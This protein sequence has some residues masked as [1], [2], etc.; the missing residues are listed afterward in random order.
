[1]KESEQWRV[2]VAIE[3]PSKA[4]RRLVEHIGQLQDS[5]PE[6]RA[7]WGHQENLHLTLKFLGNIPATNVEAL[8]Q[9]VE[10][11]A[12]SARPFELLV[13][14]CGV[15]P[16]HGAPRVLWIGIDD[17]SGWLD[18]VYRALEDE[19]AGAGFEREKRPFHPHLT[20]ARVRKPEGSGRLA[21]VH[22]EIGF[23][24]LPVGVS[25][26]SVFRSELRNEGSKHT[27]LSRH[28]FSQQRQ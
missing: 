1:M 15:F 19:C 17:P 27:V 24:A 3:L 2:F 26:L 20:I 11:T 28:E 10:R 8:S 23:P 13:E 14:G 5:I 16:P 6:A 25:G 21:A 22:K 9:A 18:K 12:F 4:R 7:S